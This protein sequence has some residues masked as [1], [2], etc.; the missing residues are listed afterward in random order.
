MMTAANSW[1][2]QNSTLIYFLV[3]QMLALA[4]GAAY[5][6]SY[7]TRLETRVNTLETRGSS[8]LSEINNRLTVT[9]KETEINKLSLRRV[10]D[11]MTKD[12]HIS[13][14]RVPPP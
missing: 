1:L 5:G 12:L 7:M 13:P 6:I 11:I 9:E 3:A 4:S 10:I 14:L 2:K 8:H